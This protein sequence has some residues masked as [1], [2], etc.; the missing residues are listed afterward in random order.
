ML[1]LFCPLAYPPYYLWTKPVT[2]LSAETDQTVF[3][4]Y[5]YIDNM[6]LNIPFHSPVFHH[7]T[8]QKKRWFGFLHFFSQLE[9]SQV[10]WLLIVQNRIVGY[11][12]LCGTNNDMVNILRTVQT[13]RCQWSSCLMPH[14]LIR[15]IIKIYVYYIYID[16]YIS[17]RSYPT[18]SRTNKSKHFN[19]PMST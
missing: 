1:S 6:S 10:L 9:A 3:V 15:P 14:D 11:E 8:Q 18:S 4:F 17:H 13:K 19:Q 2:L 12:N 16:I 7:H 5:H